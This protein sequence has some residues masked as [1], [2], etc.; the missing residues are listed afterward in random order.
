MRLAIW[1]G[2]LVLSVVIL[3][4]CGG[5]GDTGKAGGA[6]GAGQEDTF[7]GA[8]EKIKSYRYT[9]SL[10]LQSPSFQRS[11]EST[12]S[13]PLNAFA[14]SL[15]AL[16]ANMKLE[17]AYVAPDR[18]QTILRLP[19]GEVELRVIGNESWVRMGASWQ[20][21]GPASQGDTMLTPE[22][23]CQ[24][25]VKDLAPSLHGLGSQPETINGVETEHYRLDEADLKRL[26]E[27]L[28]PRP[29]SALPERFRVDLWLAREG[30]WPVRLQIAAS[31][32]DEKGQPMGLDL[33]M[34]FRDINDTTI[35]IEPP[36]VS[37][38]RR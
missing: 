2:A 33:F 12:P 37:T 30:R 32:T 5:G 10:K 36:A 16:F 22:S 18:S 24:E 13:E 8:I 20:E 1:T 26:P 35:K 27:L 4:A 23:L 28:G 3:A 7:C 29:D 25:I 19:D 14:E 9:I 11:A 17:G 34:E 31:E 15:A 21:L 6:Q 38:G